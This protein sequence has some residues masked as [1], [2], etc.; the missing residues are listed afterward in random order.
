MITQDAQLEHLLRRYGETLRQQTRVSPELFQRIVSRREQA[1]RLQS[2]RMSVQ[3]LATGA[4]LLVAVGALAIV[5]HQRAVHPSPVAPSA[6]PTGVHLGPPPPGHPLIWYSVVPS[7]GSN[8]T[9]GRQIALGWDG[10]IKGQLSAPSVSQAPDGSRLFIPGG[11][12]TDQAGRSIA[13]APVGNGG[14]KWSDDSRHFCVTRN[15]SGASNEGTTEQA[16]LFEGAI[17]GPM[18]RVAQF[19]VFGGQSTVDVAACSVLTDRAVL[20]QI[21]VS[22]VSKVRVVRLSTG[23]TLFERSYSPEVTWVSTSHDGQ[24]LAELIGSQSVIRQT[25]D[26]SI[27]ARLP[28]QRVLA[29]S[30]D[31]RHVLTLPV[32]GSSGPSEARLVDWSQGRVL[33]H[34]PLAPGAADFASAYALAEPGGSAMV[35]GIGQ[36]NVYGKTDGLWLIGANG[37]ARKIVTGA[38]NP[39]W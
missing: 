25:S 27:T 6:T 12:I 22:G 28:D 9:S 21:G 11:G 15:V 24:Y 31:G 7:E 33:W 5:L 37:N 10:Q 38:I 20:T 35:F 16:W 34:L 30:W 13:Q 32:R 3:L 26:G 36:P 18:R 4:M 17:D 8:L 39:G 2:P 19:G 1:P 29:F 23:A 14:L